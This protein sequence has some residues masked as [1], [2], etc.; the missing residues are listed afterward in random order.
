[1]Q[2][3]SLTNFEIQKH[4]QNDHKA[5]SVYSRNNLSKIKDVADIINLSEYESI[6][7][8][9]IALY[10]NAENVTNFDSFWMEY[11]PKEIKKIQRK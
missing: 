8:H 10:V 7:T 2:P 11:I 6:A 1:M 5:N 9:W 3:H 4:Y